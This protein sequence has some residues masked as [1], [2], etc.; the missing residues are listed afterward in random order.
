VH[1]NIGGGYPEHVLSDATLFWMASRI[2]PLLELDRQYLTAQAQAARRKPY[3]TGKLVDSRTLFYWLF[4][5][6]H[7]RTICEPDPSEGVHESAFLRL[8][9]TN[10]GPQPSPYGDAEFRARLNGMRDRMVFLSDFEKQLIADV[11][12]TEPE[13]ILERAH[14]RTTFC[15]WII[16]ALG[17]YKP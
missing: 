8:D 13:K 16:T 11:P 9:N 12:R 14:R 3:A 1:S 6:R 5:R 4:T 7:V 15:D 17:G 2:A 10:G